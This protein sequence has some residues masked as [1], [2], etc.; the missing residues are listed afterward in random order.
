MIQEIQEY[1]RDALLGIDALECMGAFVF[2]DAPR[3]W[4]QT[5]FP[6]CQIIIVPEVELVGSVSHNAQQYQGIINFLINQG[7]LGK[8]QDWRMV[9]ADADKTLYL[10]S[11]QRINA[12]VKAARDELQKVAHYDM[13]DL[14]DDNGEYVCRFALGDRVRGSGPGARSNSWENIGSIAFT[15]TTERVKE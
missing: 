5:F 14:T 13:G 4:P 2:G 15:V 8:G 9:T 7:D 6:A 12:M 1:I 3:P 11:Y 10:V